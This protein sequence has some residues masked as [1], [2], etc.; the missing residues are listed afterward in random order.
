MRPLVGRAD[1]TAVIP[2]RWDDGTLGMPSSGPS[3]DVRGSGRGH[4]VRRT[5]VVLAAGALLLLA[6]CNGDG[7]GASAGK[8]TA[9]RTST[10][11]PPPAAVQL[12]LAN[13]ST[14]VSPA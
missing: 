13:G 3:G 1:T 6:G 7:G 5:A 10:A 11:P 12:T 14:D 9:S 4:A 8:A 2:S